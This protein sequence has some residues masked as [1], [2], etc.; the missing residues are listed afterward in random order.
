MRA[1]FWNKTDT[2]WPYLT[3]RQLYWCTCLYITNFNRHDRP[4]QYVILNSSKNQSRK[5]AANRTRIS[6]TTATIT[7]TAITLTCLTFFVFAFPL[8]LLPSALMRNKSG[9][10]CVRRH[11]DRIFL[12]PTAHR[13]PNHRHRRHQHHRLARLIPPVRVEW[14]LS[15][16]AYWLVDVLFFSAGGSGIK[17]VAKHDDGS[18]ERLLNQQRRSWWNPFCSTATNGDSLFA[19]CLNRQLL[20]GSHGRDS[21]SLMGCSALWFSMNCWKFKKLVEW[22]TIKYFNQNFKSS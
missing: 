2:H 8:I 9:E 17:E 21:K 13:T 20:E 7:I 11:K 6:R 15:V 4:W 12:V 19:R 1:L 16:V 18:M 14:V 5:I 10:M 3:F 22:A